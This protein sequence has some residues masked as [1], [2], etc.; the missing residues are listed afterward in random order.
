MMLKVFINNEHATNP[1]SN[2]DLWVEKITVTHRH[3]A[4][5]TALRYAMRQPKSWE[6]VT[7][8]KTNKE[9]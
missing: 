7:Q 2:N 8:E 5:L 1:L 3:F 9:C 6:Y 4:W